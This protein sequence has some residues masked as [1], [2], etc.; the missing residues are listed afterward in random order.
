MSIS[1]FARAQPL[2]GGYCHGP[3]LDDDKGLATD[4][5]SSL[6]GKAPFTT[7][8]TTPTTTSIAKL[9]MVAVGKHYLSFEAHSIQDLDK[10]ADAELLWDVRGKGACK[11]VA[12][13][14]LWKTPPGGRVRVYG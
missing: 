10:L 9:P 1:S 11:D 6:D 3:S 4:H 14:L 5:G 2:R 7:P 8:A 12:T 13:I